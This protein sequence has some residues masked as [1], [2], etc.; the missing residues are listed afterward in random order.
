ML[1][2]SVQMDH[3]I[4]DVFLASRYDRKDPVGR[5]WITIAVCAKT[6]VIL[7]FYISFRYPSLASVAH[8][9]KH[10]V[11]SKEAF[12]KSV[13]LKDHE[14][15]FYGVFDEL[16]TDNAREFR[17][18]NLVA[19]CALEGIKLQHRRQKQDGG[20]CERV[21]GTLNVGF[22]HIDRKSVV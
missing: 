6:K 18:G 13:G 9:L 11:M 10:A 8:T 16:L 3:T 1:F 4:A 12:M 5:P 21:L 15:E 7:G 2:R 17:S 20:I 22:V 14:Y 19:A